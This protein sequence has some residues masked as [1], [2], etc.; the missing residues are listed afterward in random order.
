MRG[1]HP[2]TLEKAALELFREARIRREMKVAAD[3]V[4]RNP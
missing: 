3:R 4:N 2:N 1:M